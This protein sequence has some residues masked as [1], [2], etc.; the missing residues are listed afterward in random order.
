MRSF[1]L[2][3]ARIPR[4][5]LTDWK[6]PLHLL[7]QLSAHSVCDIGEFL[8]H[9]RIGH[10]LGWFGEPNAGK[11][12]VGFRLLLTIPD[13]RDAIIFSLFSSTPEVNLNYS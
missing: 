8:D 3:A 1:E 2:F 10:Q 9:H 11:D 6:Q 4:H 12:E 5:C 13:P 7:E